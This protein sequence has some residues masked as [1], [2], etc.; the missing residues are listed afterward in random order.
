MFQHG[1]QADGARPDKLG[2]VM[3]AGVVMEHQRPD[4]G[5]GRR[6]LRQIGGIAFIDESPVAAREIEQL[7]G[8]LDQPVVARHHAGGEQFQARVA[9]VHELLVKWA[10]HV[11]FVR[12]HLNAAHG[13]RNDPRQ[14]GIAAVKS[15]FVL[16][17]IAALVQGETVKGQRFRRGFDGDQAPAPGPPPQRGEFLCAPPPGKNVSVMPRKFLPMNSPR[18]PLASDLGR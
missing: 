10:V 15:A 14:F 8:P 6:V 17:G 11:G 7:D 5:E 3:P 9:V 12:A 13:Q 18:C 1:A 4:Q 2:I 16:V